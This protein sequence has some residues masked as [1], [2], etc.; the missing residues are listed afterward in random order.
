MSHE[1]MKNIDAKMVEAILNEVIQVN[2]TTWE[3]I[4]GLNTVKKII[5]EIIIWPME[6]PDIFVG[7]RAAPKGI[8][9]FGPPGTGK[10]M[11]GRVIATESRST[12]F[13]ISASS[14]TSKWI[15]DGEKMVRALFAVA[16]VK[17]PSVIFIDEIDSILTARSDSEHESSRRMKTEFLL[18]FDGC[19]TSN[20]ERILV[21]GVTNRPQELDDAARRRLVKRIYIPLPDFEARKQ[22]IKHLV[23][24]YDCSMSE[25]DFE[26]IA[27]FTEG[28]SGA[29][30]NSL[31]REAAMGPLRDV[32]TDIQNIDAA[33]IRPISIRD[34]G[35]ASRQVKSS[36]DPDDVKMYEDWD[37]KFGCHTGPTQGSADE[38]F[39][40]LTQD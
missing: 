24:N 1:L 4:A 25:A 33:N 39:E 14:L 16:R 6:R 38:S 26:K 13:N 27:K 7:L 17:A 3:D 40:F 23:K 20:E 34:F 10:T 8:L 9:F 31:C 32:N 21:I 19:G 37:V 29:D 15:G 36:V 2:P 12:F 28:Y 22:L 18:Q 35:R 11:F 5:R 30:M